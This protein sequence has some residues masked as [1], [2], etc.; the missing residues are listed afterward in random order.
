MKSNCQYVLSMNEY[1]FGLII[2]AAISL[3]AILALSIFS[4]DFRSDED[5]RISLICSL[6]FLSIDSWYSIAV[7]IFI[8]AFALVCVFFMWI[9]SLFQ[10]P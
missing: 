7:L 1:I 10:R 6:A 2:L 5:G 8:A 4:E 3:I 9:S